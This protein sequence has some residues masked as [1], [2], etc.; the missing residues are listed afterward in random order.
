M[1][2]IALTIT[3]A[4]M[5]ISQNASEETFGLG[6]ILCIIGIISAFIGW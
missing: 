1:G 3:G 6:V 5:M 4:S 2:G